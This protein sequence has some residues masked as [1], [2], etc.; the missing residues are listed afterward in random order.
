MK[1]R[2][3]WGAVARIYAKFDLAIVLCDQR[4]RTSIGT[5]SIVVDIFVWT[6]R[7]AV[8]DALDYGLV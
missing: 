3:T 6:W 5:R 1:V 8:V 2:C 4:R 7:I